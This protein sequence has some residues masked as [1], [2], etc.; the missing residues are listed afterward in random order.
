MPLTQ[1]PL[2][3]SIRSRLEKKGGYFLRNGTNE[4]V[5]SLAVENKRGH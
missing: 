5:E 2:N 1:S 3:D 4:K